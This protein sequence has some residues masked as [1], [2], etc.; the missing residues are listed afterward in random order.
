M[1]EFSSRRTMKLAIGFP[2]SGALA[3]TSD[4]RIPS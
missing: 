3:R 4:Y 1:R 2:R